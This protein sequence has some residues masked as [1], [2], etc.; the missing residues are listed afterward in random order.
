MYRLTRT[1]TDVVSCGRS[2][3][4]HIKTRT[5]VNSC[6]YHIL[7]NFFPSPGGHGSSVQQPNQR[8]SID[9]KDDDNIDQNFK[10]HHIPP[11]QE[12]IPVGLFFLY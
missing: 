12:E 1:R 6:C 10:A 2:L 3:Y 9:I 5:D 8:L 7:H 4:V 11:P